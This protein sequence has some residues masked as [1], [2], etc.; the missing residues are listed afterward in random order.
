MVSLHSS[1]EVIS[2][3]FFN[4]V[5][6]IF[7]YIL[8][9]D[10]DFGASRNLCSNSSAGYTNKVVSLYYRPPGLLI[11]TIAISANPYYIHM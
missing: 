5:V 6:S 1:W 4:S 2:C 9:P 8:S 3:K 7:E 10:T 11:K